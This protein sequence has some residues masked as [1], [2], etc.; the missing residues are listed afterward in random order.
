M[1]DRLSQLFL[2]TKPCGPQ[3]R[4][5]AGHKPAM[6]KTLLTDIPP[7]GRERGLESPTGAFIPFGTGQPAGATPPPLSPS[8]ESGQ[9][10]RCAGPLSDITPVGPEV[11]ASLSLPRESD[12]EPG[13]TPGPL[14]STPPGFFSIRL[15]RSDRR[16]GL[17]FL[18]R[19]KV[20]K[21]G[22]GAPRAPV[23]GDSLPA[24]DVGP[25]RPLFAAE[26]GP[27]LAPG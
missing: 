8:K 24:G 9:R 21:S 10:I 5:R 23:R 1:L 25:A 13:E 20:T 17:H 27:P 4:Q 3:A 26:S 6:R 16:S 11:R 14:F 18:C 12:K 2:D 7:V 22:R 15:L 19:E